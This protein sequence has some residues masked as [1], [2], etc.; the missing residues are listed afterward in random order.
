MARRRDRWRVRVLGLEIMAALLCDAVSLIMPIRFDKRPMIRK[1]YV[2][3]GRE[4]NFILF[5]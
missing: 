2:R 4:A 5:I 3:C 1:I